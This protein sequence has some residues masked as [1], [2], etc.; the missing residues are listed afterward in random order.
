MS[1]Y[2]RL[3]TYDLP[4]VIKAN[5]SKD[6]YFF[7]SGL[8]K[9]LPPG[10]VEV[11]AVGSSPLTYTATNKGVVLVTGGTVSLVEFSRDGVTFYP[12][13]ETSGQFFLCSSDQL[14]VTYSAPPSMVL[15]PT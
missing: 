13:G 11:L 8:Y 15:V 9:G 2:N 3:P 10:N 1:Q 12:T 6:W 7:W 5:T 14:R 4:L